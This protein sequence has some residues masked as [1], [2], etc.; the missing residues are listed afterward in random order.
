MA[1]L[2]APL[3]K[4]KGKACSLRFLSPAPCVREVPNATNRSCS[5][6]VPV[7]V[8]MILGLRVVG[9]VVCM[10][11]WTRVSVKPATVSKRRFSFGWKELK[12][13]HTSNATIT[14]T[15]SSS[16]H[17]DRIKFKFKLILKMLFPVWWDD[18]LPCLHSLSLLYEYA[19]YAIGIL[20]C[21]CSMIWS[22]LVVVM[23]WSQCSCMLLCTLLNMSSSPNEWLWPIIRVFSD[24]YCLF[25]KS[26]NK[27]QASRAVSWWY[28]HD[29]QKE[30]IEPLTIHQC[31][32]T[33]KPSQCGRPMT[34]AVIS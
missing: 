16:T 3:D 27:S 4:R 13:K 21:L 26:H 29:P 23:C 32:C 19:R 9:L 5:K 18:R 25:R 10:E 22:M 6:Y 1:R 11:F 20:I 2:W 28:H 30:D 31:C 17:L 15:R 7:P 14:T 8:P 12:L 33:G 24:I 34:L